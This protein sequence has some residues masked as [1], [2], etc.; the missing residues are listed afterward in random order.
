MGVRIRQRGRPGLR[1][2][3]LVCISRCRMGRVN[4]AV[5]PVPVCAAASRSPPCSTS[6]MAC[7]WMG[8]GAV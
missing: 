1:A 5:L 6:G 8:V 7:A 4:P 3:G 2:A